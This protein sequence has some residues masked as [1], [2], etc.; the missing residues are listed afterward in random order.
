MNIAVCFACNEAYIPLCKGLVL[1]LAEALRFSAGRD[2]SLHFIDI[3]CERASLEWLE[4][5]GVR[6]HGFVREDFLP[7]LPENQSPRYADAQLCR[8]FL[9][10]LVPGYDCYLW[11]DCDIWIQGTDAL[12]AVAQAASGFT[13]KIV[14]CPEYHYGYIGHRNLRY[15]LIAQRRWY[16][17]L[18]DEAL[19][20][21]LSFRPMFNS[22][23]FAMRATSPL[24]DIWAEELAALYGRD[25]SADPSVLHYA[26]QL[27]LNR[28]IHERQ[29]FVPL[30][31]LFNYACGGSSVFLNPRGKVVVGYPPCPP[32]KG[33]HLLA[34]PIYGGM[35]L[36]KG[37]L[38]NRG[39]Y[40]T[41]GERA[42]LRALV[43]GQAA[44]PA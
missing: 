9:P 17:A 7:G 37:L 5:A 31:P 32:V 41:E 36:D 38:Y 12:P 13:D 27:G 19:A 10:R 42:C 33:A 8:P 14:I 40:L 4:T 1:S 2:F 22:G 29:A 39:T 18:Y 16:G 34:F 44:A 25:H 35:Y 20:E 23:F 28:V 21:E 24:W 43:R 3:G 6:L 26:E 30:D 11:I 15:A